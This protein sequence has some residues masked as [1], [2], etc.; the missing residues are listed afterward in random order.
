MMVIM[1]L[2]YSYTGYSSSMR[3]FMI[4]VLILKFLMF[5]FLR[6]KVPQK[7]YTNNKIRD[8]VL[9]ILWCAEDIVKF[10]FSVITSNRLFA[11]IYNV[12]IPIIIIT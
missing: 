6:N 1:I 5:S 3:D 9:K 4:L 12:L 10:E 2:I 7:S 11:F 8:N